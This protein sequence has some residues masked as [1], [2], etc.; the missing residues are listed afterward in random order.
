VAGGQLDSRCG[1]SASL[2]VSVGR[3]LLSSVRALPHILLSEPSCKHNLQNVLSNLGNGTFRL[4]LYVLLKV[5]MFV[6]LVIT[7][8]D[9]MLRSSD[10]C[11]CF[12]GCGDTAVLKMALLL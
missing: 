8:H 1:E 7:S 9:H 10:S 12:N 3:S 2:M 5:H 11:S 4:Y 6:V